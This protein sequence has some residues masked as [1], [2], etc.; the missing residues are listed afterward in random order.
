MDSLHPERRR[1]KQ[2]VIPFR[3]DPL[4]PLLKEI[5]PVLVGLLTDAA[6]LMEV[7]PLHGLASVVEKRK[8]DAL[9]ADAFAMGHDVKH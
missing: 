7:G 5:F 1:S 9:A 4:P 3:A 8:A 2:F 6:L